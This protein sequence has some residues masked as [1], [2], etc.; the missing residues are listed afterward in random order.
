MCCA[1]SSSLVV[2]VCTVHCSC[3]RAQCALG[4]LCALCALFLCGGGQL[5]GG[6]APENLSLPLLNKTERRK[7]CSCQYCWQCFAILYTLFNTSIYSVL[8]GWLKPLKYKNPFNTEL[9]QQT[10]FSGFVWRTLT[11]RQ[12]ETPSLAQ[13]HG[14][15][16][17]QLNHNKSVLRLNVLAPFTGVELV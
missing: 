14:R 3:C 10:D 5:D 6:C 11:T 12:R 15:H 1:L 9:W 8:Y 2:L 16:W 4:A 7:Y 17:N 13:F